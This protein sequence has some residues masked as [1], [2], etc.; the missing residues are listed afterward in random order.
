MSFVTIDV[1]MIKRSRK[2]EMTELC[3][4]GKTGIEF[5]EKKKTFAIV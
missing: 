2:K 4:E 3:G 5:N 1:Y